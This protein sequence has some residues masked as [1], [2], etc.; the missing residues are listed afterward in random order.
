MGSYFPRYKIGEIFIKN[1][2][3]KP[4]EKVRDESDIAKQPSIVYEL[5]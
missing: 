5:S 2:R 4:R 3:E 1:Q